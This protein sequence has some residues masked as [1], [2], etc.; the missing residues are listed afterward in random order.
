MIKDLLNQGLVHR[1]LQEIR[2]K[3]AEHPH[4]SFME[5]V[6]ACEM[7]LEYM[8]TYMFKGFK[9]EKRDEMYQRMKRKLCNLW[10]DITVKETLRDTA[11]TRDLQKTLWSKD[12]S[13]EALQTSL[14]IEA[15]AKTHHEALSTAFL[16]L[17]TSYHWSSQQVEEWVPFLTSQ[18]TSQ[19]D[20][21]TLVSALS[22]SVLVNFSANKMDSLVRI[23]LES[24]DEM[25][26][27]RALVG[28][29]MAMSFVKPNM[30][31]EAQQCLD[32]LFKGDEEV[33]N[34]IMQLQL[35]M[36][37]CSNVDK[38]IKEIQTKIMPDILRNQPFEITSEGIKEKEEK[39]DIL[40]PGAEERR[41]EAMEKS[42]KRMLEMQK[43][44]VDI[45]FHGFMQM[46]RFPFFYKMVNWFVPFYNEH[47]DLDSYRANMPQSEFMDKIMQKGPFCNSD[48]YSFFIS[49]ST[50]MNSLPQNVRDALNN[51]EIGPLGMNSEGIHEDD[52]S[53]IRMKYL[54]DLFRFFRLNPFATSVNNP[55]EKTMEYRMWIAIRHNVTDKD[56]CE[57]CEHVMKKADAEVVKVVVPELMNAFTDKDSFDYLSCKAAY[58][59]QQGRNERAMELYAKCLTLKKN[60][61][62]TMRGYAKMAYMVKQ[63]STAAFIYDA[64][65]TLFPDRKSYTINYCM[66][67]VMDGKV[68]TVLNTLYKLQYES[69]EDEG[70]NNV[71]GWALL[72][73]GKAEQAYEVYM[74]IGSKDFSFVINKAYSQICTGRFA[75][76]VETLTGTPVDKVIEMFRDDTPLLQRYGINEAERA[77]II[78]KLG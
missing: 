21:A 14:I 6:G 32:A 62:A 52:P 74:K 65:A 61:P 76:A 45:F 24:N 23:Y 71:L 47:P 3:A 55:F 77:I 28:V 9:D 1:A 35:Q 16:A 72:Y 10:Y 54:Q 46:K 17:L 60:H 34:A 30:M 67:M 48:K 15:D 39:D 69:L 59:A 13:A 40:D 68:E 27:Q 19:V 29:F 2:K 70:I 51:G 8:E 11:Y 75:D 4:E 41:L 73:A 44:G 37:T 43:N 5:R 38:D 64:L 12:L 31:D 20:A 78:S 42:V 25:V 53:F 49:L 7:E 36:V 22:L 57:M 50:T 56:L 63:Y 33:G 66:A 26:R 18:R 58:M